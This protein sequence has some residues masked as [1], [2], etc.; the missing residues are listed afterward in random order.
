MNPAKH[1]P[2]FL[3]NPLHDQ[4]KQDEAT[5]IW[6]ALAKDTDAEGLLRVARSLQSNNRAEVSFQLLLQRLPEFPD[7]PLLLTQICK[8]ALVASHEEKALPYA[9]HL[10]TLAKVPTDFENALQLVAQLAHKLDLTDL[11]TDLEAQDDKSAVQWCVLAELYQIQHDVEASTAALAQARQIDDSVLVASQEI[12]LLKTQG[13][14]PQAITRLR[15]L[16]AT[17]AGNRPVNLNKLIRLLI[18]SGDLASALIEVDHW[19]KRSPG[20]KQAWL[21]RAELLTQ[22]G[23]LREAALE[24]RRAHT[25]FNKDPELRNRL[26]KALLAAGEYQ[27]AERLYFQ[28]YQEADDASA[29]KL[30]ITELT[31]LAEQEGRTEELLAD[32]ERRKRRNPREAGP[33]LALARIHEILK[34]YDQQHSALAEALRRRPNDAALRVQLARMEENA[35]LIDQASNT[36]RDGLALAS[37]LQVRQALVDFYFRNGELER[38]LDLSG[39]LNQDDPRAI[40]TTVLSLCQKQEWELALRYLPPSSD[41]RLQCLRALALVKLNHDQEANLLLAELLADTTATF[42]PGL[43][44][45]NSPGYRA[46]MSWTWGNHIQIE[47]KQLLFTH[48][49]SQIQA[50]IQNRPQE[51][52]ALALTRNKPQTDVLPGNA[53][54]LRSFALALISIKSDT[55]SDPKESAQFLAQFPIPNDVFY[56]A[57]LNPDFGEWLLDGYHNQ[58]LTLPQIISYLGHVEIPRES[59]IAALNNPDFVAEHPA[60]AIQVALHL[61]HNPTKENHRDW[62]GDILAIIPLLKDA[63]KDYYLTQYRSLFLENEHSKSFRKIVWDQIA[64]CQSKQLPVSQKPWFH[65]FRRSLFIQNLASDYLKLLNLACQEFIDFPQL[66]NPPSNSPSAFSAVNPYQPGYYA[67]PTPQAYPSTTPSF[68]PPSSPLPPFVFQEF[69]S[70]PFSSSQKKEATEAQLRLLKEWHRQSDLQPSPQNIPNQQGLNPETF[71]P[72]IPQIKNERVRALAYQ[73]GGSPRGTGGS[74]RSI[75]GQQRPSTPALRPQLLLQAPRPKQEFL[76]S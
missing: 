50:F 58:R 63:E 61:A 59:L 5:Q 51:Y 72:L 21:Q 3:A 66:A 4:S 11:I 6:L 65:H 37:G 22:S 71:L 30:A 31:S 60:A 25:K 40:E 53:D 76:P 26:A 62:T 7:N 43:T 2:P 45:T 28:I 70:T 35:G 57:Q 39:E 75:R 41:I 34:Q 54:E 19:K 69:A 16:I 33:L 46:R 29:R 48:F 14:W 18:D 47:P 68:P 36:L 8:V 74:H 38:G 27:G 12:R 44:V 49:S 1:W 24:L 23:R 67:P 64:H 10:A 55:L 32:F 17:P 15:E 73:V 9:L 13:D 42:P 56:Q 20:D 52:N